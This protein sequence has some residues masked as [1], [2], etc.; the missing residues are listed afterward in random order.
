MSYL[1]DCLIIVVFAAAFT[2]TFIAKL[3]W[4]V[5]QSVVHSANV[6]T[7]YSSLF[8]TWFFGYKPGCD[9]KE[10]YIKF[11]KKQLQKSNMKLQFLTEIYS[12]ET[13]DYEVSFE[14]IKCP[15]GWDIL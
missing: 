13:E 6:A 10:Y 2:S 12:K 3:F 15:K 1:K 14:K 5:L 7:I 11:L 9:F 4:N 8:T